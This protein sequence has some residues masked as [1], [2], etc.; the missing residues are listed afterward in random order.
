MQVKSYELRDGMSQTCGVSANCYKPV[1]RRW[2]GR[3]QKQ[4]SGVRG[5]MPWF[6]VGQTTAPGWLDRSN[7]AAMSE[8]T[9]RV[10]QQ[11]LASVGLIHC[12]LARLGNGRLRSYLLFG[13][14]AFHS[15]TEPGDN[16]FCDGCPTFCSLLNISVWES[17]ARILQELLGV[18]LWSCDTKNIIKDSRPNETDLCLNLTV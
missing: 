5:G 14:G 17:F 13:S 3:G 10:R 4:P 15:G 1:A 11:R 7:M 12:L 16:G 8:Q 6:T 9:D 18:W 2:V